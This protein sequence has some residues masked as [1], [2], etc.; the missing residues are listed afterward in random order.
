MEIYHERQRQMLCA[1]HTL[2]NLF[3]DRNAYSKTDL[4]AISY[5]LSPD[6][7]VNPHKNMLGLGNYDVNVLMAALQL[8]EYEAVWFD[9]RLGLETLELQQIFGF[10]VNKPSNVNLIW[11]EVP[12]KRPHWFAVRK[13]ND[14]YYNLDSKLSSPQC[15]GNEEKVVKF[16]TDMLSLPAVQLFI[17]VEK[18]VAENSLWKRL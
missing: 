16:L 11:L 5:N 10:V 17:I 4:D 3:Q 14:N 9:K 15:I 7:F 18:S 1:V 6:A 12:I 8:K 13:I 2:N